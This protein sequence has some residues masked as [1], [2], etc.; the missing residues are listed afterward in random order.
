MSVTEVPY[1]TRALAVTLFEDRAEVTRG[2]TLTAPAGTTW[3]R[4]GGVTP[5][6]DDRSLRVHVTAGE[7]QVHATRVERRLPPVPDSL[8]E[9]VREAS[10]ALGEARR[11]LG[12]EER[13]LEQLTALDQSLATAFQ[14]CPQGVEREEVAAGWSGSHAALGTA[15]RFALARLAEA[16]QQ[17]S[18]RAEAQQAAE[19]ALREAHG[20]RTTVAAVAV[21]LESDGGE[22][23]LELRYRTPC[24]S[25]RPEHLARLQTLEPGRGTLELTTFA[26][27]WQATQ[28]D[29]WDEVTLRFSTARP[30]RAA[31]A[32][33][34]P[35]DLL[36]VQP[37]HEKTIA[38]EARDEQVLSAVLGQG[39]RAV[40]DMPG[41]DDGGQPLEWTAAGTKR[42]PP[43]GQPLR[44][45][46]ERRSVE[47][48]V[49]TVA[50]P[51]LSA[52]PHLRAQGTLVGDAPLLAGPV[53][54]ARQQSVVG[55]GRVSFVGV[56]ESFTLGFG[57]EGAVSVRRELE[58]DRRTV[59]VIGTQKL[60]RKVT[61]H[62]SN[63]G[64]APQRLQVRER[65][66]VSELE[67]VSVEVTAPGWSHDGKD[68][69][70]TRTVELGPRGHET[71]SYSVLL[72]ASSKVDLRGF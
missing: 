46:L 11:V 72:S 60:T 51:E 55:R 71:L 16:R 4:L 45:E 26:C 37:R 21:Q 69:F 33:E 58:R 43:N 6:V 12:R 7:A 57:A 13:E 25:W 53:R 17:V 48:E 54:L 47:V 15:A 20:S 61:V 8:A 59:P 56:G 27:A 40:S 49:D 62:L 70:L 66:P 1:L 30:G 2:A 32:P 14:A 65:A 35:E 31:A 34:L 29:D 42:L 36:R 50:I 5:L 63:L 18:E 64:E 52:A 23:T 22:V 68:G 28:E 44:I 38:V 9:A 24:A 41:V 10:E 67:A 19:Q 39:R 3:I